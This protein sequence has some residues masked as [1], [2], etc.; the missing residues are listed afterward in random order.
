MTLQLKDLKD[1]HAGPSTWLFCHQVLVCTHLG[2]ISPALA[3]ECTTY[4]AAASVESAIMAT[5][6]R[7]MLCEAHAIEPLSSIYLI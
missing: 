2:Q 7:R 1:E 5:T 3:W 6:W 4:N